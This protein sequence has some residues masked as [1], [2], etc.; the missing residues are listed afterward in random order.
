MMQNNPLVSILLLS[1][2]HEDY[3]EQCIQSLTTQ[4]YKN[5]EVIYMDNFS[6]DNTFQKGKLLLEQ[7]G[8]PFKCYSN[9][10]SKTISSNLNFL[11][12]QSSGDLV[13][14]LSSDDWFEKNNIE[15][16]VNYF[17]HNTEA[18]ALFSNGWI[19]NEVDKKLILND[20]STFRKGYIYKEV[21]THAD[22]IFYVG[23]IYRREII[24]KVG[25]WDESLLIE[26]TDMFIRIGLEA[27][28]EYLEEPLVYYRRTISSA[29]KNKQFMLNGF[30]QYYEKYKHVKWINMKKWLAE[31]YRSMA[32]SDIDLKQNQQA[33]GFLVQAIKLNP[34]G[35]K[36]IRTLF[37]LF[38]RSLQDKFI[39]K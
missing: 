8:I 24:E 11:F 31:R 22:C 33:F 29:S 36:N 16:K 2:N 21:L 10:E 13:S 6:S 26:D 30:R 3:I 4:T 17:I 32:A 27:T 23:M 28:I 20:S 1:M 7:S 12:D 9:K 38:R 25:K 34:M 19:Y 15:K 18:G 37:Y 5:I 35:I 14:P 39:T